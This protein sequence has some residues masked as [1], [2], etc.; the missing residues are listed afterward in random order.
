QTY[1][2]TTKVCRT[3]DG[4][5]TS[6]NSEWQLTRTGNNRYT[7]AGTNPPVTFQF[8]GPMAPPN[9]G[10]CPAP[11]I[12]W[13]FGETPAG[14]SWTIL[15]AACNTDCSEYDQTYTVSAHIKAMYASGIFQPPYDTLLFEGDFSGT[16]SKVPGPIA[17][18]HYHTG[19]VWQGDLTVSNLSGTAPY[20]PTAILSRD[21]CGWWLEMGGGYPS[22]RCHAVH[23]C[24]NTSHAICDSPIGAFDDY[25]TPCGLTAPSNYMWVSNIRVTGPGDAPATTT[26]TMPASASVTSTIPVAAPSTAT[27]ATFPRS[28][29][30]FAIPDNALDICHACGSGSCM[31][32]CRGCGGGTIVAPC[33]AGR[34]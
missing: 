12:G 4:I 9:A 7:L 10:P 21:E 18:I 17:S 24:S 33:P 19:C 31:S 32:Y 28:A 11:A 2:P 22:Q 8:P 27:S 20:A 23:K 1:Y 34:W 3:S 13:G 26:A 29:T 6:Q 5:W 25:E 15:L 14:G 16:L 30:A